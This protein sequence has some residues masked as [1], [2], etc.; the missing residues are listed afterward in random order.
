[1]DTT[2][3][4]CCNDFNK[5]T[6]T[7]IKC[8]NQECKVL[9]CKECVRTYLSTQTGDPH[10]MGCKIAFD[11]NFIVMNLNRTWCEKD[12]RQHRKGI[13]LE[14]QM[15]RMPETVEAAERFNEIN[16]IAEKNIELSNQIA[17]LRRAI[18]QL[19]IERN[20]NE[21]RVYNLNRHGNPEGKEQEKRKFIMA[22]PDDDCRG[23]LSTGYKCEMCKLFT[24]SHCLKI[25]GPDKNNHNHV[26]NEDDVKTAD[27]IKSTTKPCPGCGER[28]FKIEGCDQMWCT[29]CHVAFSWKT[30]IVDNGVV[31]NPHFY[32][33]QRAGGGAPMRN[34]GEIACG[35]MPN[36]WNIRNI[37]R[38]RYYVLHSP[39][40]NEFRKFI[41]N[42]GDL[43]RTF[44]HIQHYELQRARQKIRDNAN[45]EPDRI[46]YL[47]KQITKEE[48]A[49]NVI[50]K[51]KLRRK[52]TEL[53]HIYE[54]IHVVSVDLFRWIENYIANEA[55]KSQENDVEL[56]IMTNINEKINE[57][58][59]LRVYAN[60]QLGTISVSYNQ[61]VP[62]FRPITWTM[63]SKKFS[64]KKAKA[65][66]KA[67]KGNQKIGNNEFTTSSSSV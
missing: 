14:Q 13:L 51:D 53:V 2:C 5:S 47:L 54:L 59:A 39:H 65:K 9:A 58:E 48:L 61:K 52:Y 12:Y 17:D 50:R 25:I 31:H 64:L 4:I 44:A 55:P 62:Q 32:A 18:R 20:R 1:M 6:R 16:A 3:Q 36:W 63:D 37:M 10:C 42:I 23:Y 60:E 49:N 19:E 21:V 33:H 22:C 35:G 57:L 7:P 41:E 66:A 28:I 45:H 15:A 38:N 46:R 34:P 29:Q 27:F 43:H 24:C 67:S 40:R 30:G 56:I 11:D 8:K 26:C